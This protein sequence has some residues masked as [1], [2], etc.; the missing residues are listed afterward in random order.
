[1]ANGKYKGGH[2]VVGYGV[3]DVGSDYK[4]KLLDSNSKE[5][6][7]FLLIS[8]DYNHASYALSGGI[9]YSTQSGT[10]RIDSINDISV[11]DSKNIQDLLVE[12]RRTKIL[13]LFDTMNSADYVLLTTNYH[14]FTI[15]DDE[16]REATVAGPD[17]VGDIDIS[18]PVTDISLNIDEVRN[19]YYLENITGYTITPSGEQDGYETTITYNMDQ[20]SFCGVHTEGM[21]VVEFNSDGKVAVNHE[22]TGLINA[23]TTIDSFV[24]P[25]YNVGV[26]AALGDLVLIPSDDNVVVCSSQPLGHIDVVAS[27]DHNEV[28]LTLDVGE[29]KI[30]VKNTD[31]SSSTFSLLSEKTGI[32]KDNVTIVNADE[33]VLV[34]KPVVY[35]A[36]F[37]TYGGS[38]VE[39]IIDIKYNS[40]INK[41]ED[42]TFEGFIFGGWYKDAECTD[43]QEWNFYV[44]TI[45]ED[46]TLH[47]KWEED[48]SYTHRVIFSAAGDDDI[49]C[50]VR[51]QD[52][53]ESVPPVPEREGFEVHWEDADLSNIQED[54][55]VNAIFISRIKGDVSGDGEVDVADA[56]LLL[57]HIV[58]LTDLD[59]V[60]LFR[61]K[62]SEGGKEPN[63]GDVILI[64]RY[65]VGLIDGFT[66]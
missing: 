36:N 42:P 9:A 1:M 43:G 6:K 51:D 66:E 49:I 46:T 19:N 10:L 45:I 8:K 31:S 27:N 32:D 57:R 17:I 33:E 60:A 54:I 24:T 41:P 23:F 3:E 40:T 13:S 37:N 11:F 58:G 20:G 25:W 26:E 15:T 7:N 61:A 2:A 52:S 38:A 56:I 48:E 28:M 47:A 35:A 4:I 59:E 34:N 62:V 21:A 44:D 53:L 39:T 55:T 16:G 29:K 18:P 14:D 22:S 50:I 5:N 12:R 30:I 63:V 65:I 64:L